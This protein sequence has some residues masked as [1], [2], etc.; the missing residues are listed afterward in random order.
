MTIRS[1]ILT[2]NARQIS[3]HGDDL[4]QDS[5][6][7]WSQ[8]QQS[9]KPGYQPSAYPR[10]DRPTEFLYG[11]SAS[12][13]GSQQPSGISK[14]MTQT[15]WSGRPQS[16]DKMTGSVTQSPENFSW[17]EEGTAQTQGDDQ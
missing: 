16:S 9:H 2:G 1:G 12:Q 10:A 4:S 14:S 5:L 8:E 6:A 17:K 7:L 3:K 13:T 11:A 15:N